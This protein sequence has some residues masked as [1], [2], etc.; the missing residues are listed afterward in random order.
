VGPSAA[1]F[2]TPCGDILQRYRGGGTIPEIAAQLRRTRASV[3]EVIDA[4]GIARPRRS[5]KDTGITPQQLRTEYEAGASLSELADTH[6]LKR[7]SLHAAL[8]KAGTEM[9]PTGRRS[10]KTADATT[11]DDLSG[12]PP[13][14][15]A[16]P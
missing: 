13:N 5:V 10:P 16:Q 2:P 14:G 1:C 11:P 12:R 4:A 6:D 8:L 9:R 7:G 3:R 15:D